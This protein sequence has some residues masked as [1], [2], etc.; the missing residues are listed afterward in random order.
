MGSNEQILFVPIKKTHCIIRGVTKY[1]ISL[2]LD[3]NGHL[4]DKMS[5]RV[6][7]GDFV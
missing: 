4:F 3:W 6:S 2:V 5:L 7:T 1:R